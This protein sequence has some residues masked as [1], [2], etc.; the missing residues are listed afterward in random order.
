MIKVA[1]K[2]EGILCTSQEKE[3]TTGNGVM[4]QGKQLLN[5]LSKKVMICRV[6]TG[7]VDRPDKAVNEV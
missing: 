5:V 1:F 3:I 7:C 4:D 6:E 2:K